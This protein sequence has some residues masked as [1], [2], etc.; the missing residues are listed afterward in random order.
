[1]ALVDGSGL[2]CRRCACSDGGWRRWSDAV[3][4]FRWRPRRAQI[5]PP[6]AGECR[7]SRLPVTRSGWAACC[8][9]FVRADHPSRAMHRRGRGEGNVRASGSLVRGWLR[10]EALGSLELLVRRARER[11]WR[12][13]G[14]EYRLDVLLVQLERA[15]SKLLQGGARV[16]TSDEGAT[17][18]GDPRRSWRCGRGRPKAKCTC[19][20]VHGRGRTTPGPPDA[21]LGSRVSPARPARSWGTCAWK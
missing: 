5:S 2:G 1:M 12:S 19:R 21:R 8:R 18:H 20:L 17:S 16:D 3:R 15:R 13:V 6:E 9:A 7:V 4:S 14:L 11:G 10:A